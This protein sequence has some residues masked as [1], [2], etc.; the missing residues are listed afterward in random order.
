MSD[1]TNARMEDR[2]NYPKGTGSTLS[3]A[4]GKRGSLPWMALERV[5][6]LSRGR[7][8]SESTSQILL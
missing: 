3:L 2:V 6:A 5:L 4:L 1:L 7:S 8:A